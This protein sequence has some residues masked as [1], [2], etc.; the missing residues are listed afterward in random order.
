MALGA[1]GTIITAMTDNHYQF[2]LVTEVFC[3]ALI[4][5]SEIICQEMNHHGATF[6][7]SCLF[8]ILLKLGPVQLSNLIHWESDEMRKD[9]SP[10]ERKLLNFTKHFTIM[11]TFTSVFFS[12]WL[13]LFSY[14]RKRDFSFHLSKRLITVTKSPPDGTRS[15]GSEG[16]W[17]LPLN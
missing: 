3:S 10:S 17:S 11:A 8:T 2:L 7:T 1:S 5:W 16:I 6:V 14:L 15:Y 12:I 4:G 13:S 9:R